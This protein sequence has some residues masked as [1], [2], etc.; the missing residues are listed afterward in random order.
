MALA[1]GTYS[2]GPDRG[3]LLLH[4]TREGMAARAGHDLTIEVG[5]WD[6]HAVVDA[7]DWSRCSVEVTVRADSLQILAGHG[8]VKPL[9]DGDRREIRKTIAEKVLHTDRHPTISFGSSEVSGTPEQFVVAGEL[10]VCGQTH[11]LSVEGRIVDD[12]EVPRATGE[13][14]VR[15]TRWG[16]TPYKGFLG[17]LKVADDVTVSFDI[18]LR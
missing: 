12:Q 14:T 8:G 13:A 2:L 16:V 17:A 1:D 18:G 5:D 15:Q 3:R 4:T 11:P 9:T 6:G 10:T 7:A